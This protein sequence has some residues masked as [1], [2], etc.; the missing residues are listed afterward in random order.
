MDSHHPLAR[1]GFGQNRSLQTEALFDELEKGNRDIAIA[2]ATA[3]V[4]E[5]PF[6]TRVAAWFRGLRGAGGEPSRIN[7]ARV[8]VRQADEAGPFHNFPASFDDQIFRQGQ[9]LTVS[10]DYVQYT[11]RGAVNGRTGTF[12]VG[13]RPSASGRTEVITHRFFRPDPSP[14]VHE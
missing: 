6:L 11:L 3:L 9:R 4:G 1:T 7:S 2:G 5:A 13:V 10:E 12:E 8:L 14:R